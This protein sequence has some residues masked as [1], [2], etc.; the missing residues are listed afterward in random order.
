MEA[1]L[2]DGRSIDGFSANFGLKFPEND[3]NVISRAAVVYLFQA[4]V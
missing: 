3:F 2:S 1:E 4:L